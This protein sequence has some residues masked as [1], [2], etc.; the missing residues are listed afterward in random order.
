MEIEVEEFILKGYGDLVRVIVIIRDKVIF[1]GNVGIIKIW[2]LK[3][4]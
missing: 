4:C 1:G 3:D 2:S